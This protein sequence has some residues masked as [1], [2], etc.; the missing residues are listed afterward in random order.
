MY[1]E[2]QRRH[3]LSYP[4]LFKS[5][6]ACKLAPSKQPIR[7]D[8]LV[9]CSGSNP[10]GASN[11]QDAEY[12]LSVVDGK[13]TRTGRRQESTKAQ[14]E[15]YVG[16]NPTHP[17]PAQFHSL[18]WEHGAGN[19]SKFTNPHSHPPCADFIHQTLNVSHAQA[20]YSGSMTKSDHSLRPPLS[21]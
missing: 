16:S 4:N 19:F 10:Q 17:I 7:I 1:E 2:T 21:I 18:R 6:S 20:L 11:Y 12:D 5:V 3:T 13:H 9:A 15:E 8:H 14:A